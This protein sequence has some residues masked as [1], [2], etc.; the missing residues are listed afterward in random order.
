MS[1]LSVRRS[2]WVL[3][4]FLAFTARAGQS[5]IALAARASTLGVGAELSF[6]AGRNLGIRLGGNYLQF[7]HDATIEDISY[8]VTPHFENGTAILDVF[9][10]GS[11]L[12]LSG[13]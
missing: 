11:S 4:G 10:F 1:R 5:Q 9:P 3:A 12:H 2:V 8:H 13:G 7:S 6:R